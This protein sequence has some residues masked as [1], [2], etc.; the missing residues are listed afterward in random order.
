M[1]GR[2]RVAARRVQ[3]H[4]INA[5]QELLERTD[6][7]TARRHLFKLGKVGVNKARFLNFCEILRIVLRDVSNFPHLNHLVKLLSVLK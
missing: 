6:V 5:C 4:S 1:A 7:H 2:L 3:S